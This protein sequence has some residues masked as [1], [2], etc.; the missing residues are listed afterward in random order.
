[1]P[2]AP[3]PGPRAKIARAKEHLADLADL[4]EGIRSSEPKPYAAV[5]EIQTDGK[6]VVRF[7]DVAPLPQDVSLIL[8]DLIHNLR[9]A[10]DILVCDLIRH[11]GEEVTDDTGFPIVDR[12]NQLA[13]RVKRKMKGAGKTAKEAVKGLKPYQSGNLDLWVLHK[14]DITDK[15]KILITAVASHFGLDLSGITSRKITV[16]M[17]QPDGT[18]IVVPAADKPLQAVAPVC[19]EDGDIIFGPIDPFEDEDEIGIGFAIA[20]REP[21]VVDC[22]PILLLGHKLIDLVERIVDSFDPL[23]A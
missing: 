1:M 13:T 14:L 17:T 15:H 18:E 7:K 16:I 10:L 19:L 4:R 6:L 5:R 11:N 3:P 20:V 8:G 23:F 21:G 9:S 2:S 22:E 12:S